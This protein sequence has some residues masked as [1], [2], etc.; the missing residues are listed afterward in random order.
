MR[1]HRPLLALAAGL[2]IA[3]AAATAQETPA[4]PG[5]LLQPGSPGLGSD[6]LRC[7]VGQ[8]GG[9]PAGAR[10]HGGGSHASARQQG[11]LRFGRE[12]GHRGS[13]HERV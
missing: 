10:R 13:D 3:P 8:G 1:A 11:S 9:P 6:R 2:A 4:P 12:G 5:V 7:T